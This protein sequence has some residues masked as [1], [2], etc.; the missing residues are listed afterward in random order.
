MD[1]LD[2]M[3]YELFYYST[4]F[5]CGFK[6]SESKER[7]SRNKSPQMVLKRRTKS[8]EGGDYMMNWI[9]RDPATTAFI[10]YSASVDQWLMLWVV[11]GN[12]IVHRLANYFID[13]GCVLWTFLTAIISLATSSIVITSMG[14]LNTQNFPVHRIMGIK[15]YTQPKQT[16]E[17]SIT[18]R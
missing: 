17:H 1:F 2:E 13:F 14:R 4:F 8:S 10:R 12:L 9:V 18:I 15:K 6:T 16:W 5:Y 11:V 7:Q 3:S